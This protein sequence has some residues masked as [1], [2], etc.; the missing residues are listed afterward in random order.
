M[1]SRDKDG[2]EAPNPK[3]IPTISILSMHTLEDEGNRKLRSA[4]R[5][6]TGQADGYPRCMQRGNQALRVTAAADRAGVILA[7]KLSCSI[8]QRVKFSVADGDLETRAGH[9]APGTV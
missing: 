1:A 8:T 7:C 5:A 9:Q 6:S 4:D 3:P 2:S